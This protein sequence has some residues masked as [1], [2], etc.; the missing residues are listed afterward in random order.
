MEGLREA[1]TASFVEQSR[2]PFD[3]NSRYVQG[4]QSVDQSGRGT[5]R[6]TREM[7]L[8][9]ENRR[10]RRERRRA[11]TPRPAPPPRGRE[12]QAAR[13][14][15]PG[16]SGQP[17]AAIL[18]ESRAAGCR[19]S[20]LRGCLLRHQVRDRRGYNGDLYEKIRRAIVFART[21]KP[22]KRCCAI[23]EPC[24]P[25]RPSVRCSTRLPRTPMPW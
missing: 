11:R 20:R 13:P 14:V 7:P 5:G 6:S 25:T 23:N 2:A 3:G 16:V 17:V 10:P 1:S 22:S 4:V 18:Q 24:Q 8:R 19:R 15:G 12:P 9:G 21:G